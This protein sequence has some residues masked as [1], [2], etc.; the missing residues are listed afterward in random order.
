M[1]MSLGFLDCDENVCSQEYDF[2]GSNMTSS[3]VEMGLTFYPKL[4]S[5]FYFLIWF[6]H[7]QNI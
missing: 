1:P 3:V 7:A 6:F 5:N 2:V 4:R